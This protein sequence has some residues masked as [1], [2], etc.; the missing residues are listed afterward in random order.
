MC[1][2]LRISY[3]QKTTL[4][5]NSYKANYNSVSLASNPEMIFYK[6]Y[7]QS[8]LRHSTIDYT[9]NTSGTH[10][11]SKDAFDSFLSL[12]ETVGNNL[13]KQGRCSRIGCRQ[14]LLYKRGFGR[15]RQ[16]PVRNS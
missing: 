14:K 8:S 7:A 12:M 6:P 13:E 4:L 11:I 15:T 1:I 10:G 9:I 3:G 2:S 16:A 5:S